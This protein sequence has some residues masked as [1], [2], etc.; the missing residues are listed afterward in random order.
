MHS[1]GKNNAEEWPGSRK[2]DTHKVHTS[3][4]TRV[5]LL[6]HVSLLASEEPL[7]AL[8]VQPP[9]LRGF[10]KIFMVP[11]AGRGGGGSGIRGQRSGV[12]PG[13]V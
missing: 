1:Q 10:E 3:C 13:G 7:K 11:L 5:P 9:W 2:I 8:M 6:P 4:G 12:C